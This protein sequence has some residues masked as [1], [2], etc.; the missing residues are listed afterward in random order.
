[1]EE[2]TKPIEPLSLSIE[3]SGRGDTVT[4]VAKLGDEEL[5]RDKMD[6]NRASDRCRFGR[7]IHAKLHRFTPTDVESQLLKLLADLQR[8]EQQREEPPSDDGEEIAALELTRPELIIRHDYAAMIVPRLLRTRTAPDGT[9]T[10]Y[11]KSGGKRSASELEPSVVI[12]DR[13][14]HVHPMPYPP[15]VADVSEL[16]RWSQASREAWLKGEVRPTTDDALAAIL[17]RLDRFIELPDDGETGSRGHGATLALW[18]LMSY[19]YPIFP[20]VPYLYLAGPAGS[21]KTRTMD[22]IGRMVFRPMFSSNTTAANV[23]RSLHARGGTLLLDEA[24]RLKDDRSPEVGEITSILLS[25]YRRGGRA[26]RLEPAGDSFRSVSFDVFSP[27]LLACIRGLPPALSSRC[28][29]VRL[30][31]AAVGSPRAARSLDDSPVEEQQVRDLLHAW[32]LENAPR[33]IDTPPPASTLANRDAE[34]WEP[35]FRIASLCSDESLLE[36]VIAHAAQQIETDQEDATPEADPALL[37][38]LHELVATQPR[39]TPGDV[40][41]AARDLDPD[42]IDEGWTARRVSVVLRR[43]GLRVVRSHGKRVFKQ[44]AADVAK[45]AK[46]YGYEIADG[47]STGGEPTDDRVPQTQTEAF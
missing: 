7:A 20:A 44:T 2:Q 23:F 17:G 19:C 42:A 11:A 28:I 5:H 45:V 39:V 38:A 29:N 35:L 36:F 16:C 4:V 22:L 14:L 13:S 43:Y 26:N 15:S 30:S 41:E 6:L 9:W 33:L 27:K 18:M 40:L 3:R 21:G 10:L 25:G 1:M 12:G 34:R 31:R 24:E 46:R 8:Q 37:A 32:M 47:S